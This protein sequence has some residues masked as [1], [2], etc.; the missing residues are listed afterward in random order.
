MHWEV[1]PKQSWSV[2]SVLHYPTMKKHSAH[3]DMR[4]EQSRLRTK[5]WSIWLNKRNLYL[6]CKK[7]LHDIKLYWMARVKEGMMLKNFENSS[8]RAR[9]RCRSENWPGRRNLKRPN[10]NR[11][12]RKR[13]IKKKNCERLSRCL[14]WSTSMRIKCLIESKRMDSKK[15]RRS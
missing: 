14:I 8:K 2:Q 15:E 10:D 3:S 7:K 5:L 1:T 9:N 13:M 4:I 6:V 12:S 11:S